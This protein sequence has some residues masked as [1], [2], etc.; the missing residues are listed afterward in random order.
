MTE[1]VEV[2]ETTR[3]DG[4]R[5]KKSLNLSKVC[6]WRERRGRERNMLCVFLKTVC[7]EEG[8]EKR[9]EREKR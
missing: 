3:S 9:R 8:L 7:E 6:Q 2:K 4:G 1:V 5:D